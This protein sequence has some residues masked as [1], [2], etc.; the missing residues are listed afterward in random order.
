[1][2]GSTVVPGAKAILDDDDLETNTLL[3][4]D[5]GPAPP[6]GLRA[7]LASRSGRLACVVAV[8]LALLFVNAQAGYHRQASTVV[9]LPCRVCSRRVRPETP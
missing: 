3:D 5:K 8:V 4:V 2:A 7:C 9:W 6:S 1:M